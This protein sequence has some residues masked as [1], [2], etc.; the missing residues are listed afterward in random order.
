MNAAPG[1][2][3]EAVI[4]WGTTGATIGVRV[5]DNEGAT[6]VARLAGFAEYPAGSGIYSRVGNVA[7]TVSGQYTLVYDD[8]GGT[9]A[10]GHVATDDLLVSW[11]I[12]DIPTPGAPYATVQE[13]ARLLKVDATT[14]VDQLTEVLVSA[15]GEIDSEL[16]REDDDPLAEAWELALASQ[17]NLE[18]AEEHWMQRQLSFG[19][20]GLD[21]DGPVRLA[22]DT[23]D[24]HAHK[25]APLKETWG[26]A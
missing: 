12:P 17:V 22:R 7:P 23:W 6:T 13:L 4:D 21:A 24:R 11:S 15:A 9:A 5:I 20:I 18:R 1:A 26:L 25:L 8:D 16:G 2:T 14:Y 19:I 3:Y 10:I